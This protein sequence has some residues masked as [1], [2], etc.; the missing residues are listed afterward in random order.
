MTKK[1]EMIKSELTKRFM[2]NRWNSVTITMKHDKNRITLTPCSMAYEM[3]SMDDVEYIMTQG[4]GPAAWVEGEPE[5]VFENLASYENLAE[6]W[7][8]ELE[9]L[10]AF[11]AKHENFPYDSNEYG[12][13]SDWH[14][15]LFR[16][17]PN[18]WVVGKSANGIVVD[19]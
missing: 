1:A 19:C 6:H 13:Y 15:D 2:E 8:E 11:C 7:K 18:G 3:R 17:R 12:F 9:K 10:K 14:K 5:Q 4:Y 16:F